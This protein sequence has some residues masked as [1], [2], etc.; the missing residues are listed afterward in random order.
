MRKRYGQ[1]KMQR[2]GKESSRTFVL[3]SPGLVL[4]K[5]K[6]GQLNSQFS[7]L[8]AMS[9]EHICEWLF[10]GRMDGIFMVFPS[11][12]KS[13]LSSLYGQMFNPL[14]FQPARLQ[15]TLAVPRDNYKLPKL[16]G[17]SLHPL[18]AL[19]YRA[20]GEVQGLEWLPSSAAGWLQPSAN[21]HLFSEL[22]KW[23]SSICLT[24]GVKKLNSLV[25]TKCF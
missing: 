12:S 7:L 8:F 13:D 10:Q 24:G 14:C 15:G 2:E 1:L 20:E 4:L 21:L 9:E 3:F 6:R 5:I 17:T 23:D 18:K 19:R 11:N 25:F 22:C 16:P